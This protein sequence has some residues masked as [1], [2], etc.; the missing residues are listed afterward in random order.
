MDP[1]SKVL[2]I[3]KFHCNCKL[4]GGGGGGGLPIS[5]FNSNF[6]Y[7]CHVSERVVA[8]IRVGVC[9]ILHVLTGADQTIRR[10]T[11]PGWGLE[12]QGGRGLWIR[13]TKCNV[14]SVILF[15]FWIIFYCTLSPWQ[16]TTQCAKHLTVDGH[17]PYMG[18]MFT[19]VWTAFIRANLCTCDS[20]EKINILDQQITAQNSIF[21]E[22]IEIGN[23]CARKRQKSSYL[24]QQ[25][26]I[27]NSP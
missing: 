6:H 26:W 25:K 15:H 13:N 23:H 14:S 21:N 4:H 1:R 17:L 11:L 2:N 24:K 27:F 8:L 5:N 9:L 19:G 20:K 3:M 7:T 10:L 16:R 18:Q 22:I 12:L